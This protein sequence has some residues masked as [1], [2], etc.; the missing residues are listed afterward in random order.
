MMLDVMF[1]SAGALLDFYV[2]LRIDGLYS[3]KIQIDFSSTC[4]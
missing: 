2:L 1:G 3:E 4:D